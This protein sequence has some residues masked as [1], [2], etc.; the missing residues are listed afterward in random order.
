MMRFTHRL[1]C[2]HRQR[3]VLLFS[4]YFFFLMHFGLDFFFGNRQF[5]A[6]KLRASYRLI[7][8]YNINVCR[9]PHGLDWWWRF[10]TSGCAPLKV[11]GS[12]PTGAI[13]V[14]GPVFALVLNGPQL[15]D[16]LINVPCISRFLG[17]ILGLNTS[18]PQ[19]F[20]LSK[21]IR[22]V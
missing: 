14:F 11:S 3:L 21:L 13:P 7:D 17:R 10:K 5:L 8:L 22:K 18:M 20:L 2:F 15:V 6:E 1:L 9:N 19:L 12:N 4:C 16:G